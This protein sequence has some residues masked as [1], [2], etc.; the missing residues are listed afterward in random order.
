LQLLSNLNLKKTKA[1]IFLKSANF[2]QIPSVC[3]LI[4]DDDDDDEKKTIIMFKN[5]LKP[6]LLYNFLK[7]LREIL[8]AFYFKKKNGLCVHQ[9]N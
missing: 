1:A 7:K 9:F 8:K 3:L 2:H 5:I 4:T 6:I